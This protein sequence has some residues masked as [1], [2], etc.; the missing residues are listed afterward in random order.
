MSKRKKLFVSI[1]LLAGLLLMV[2]F[3]C[4]KQVTSA[5]QRKLFSNASEVP[6]Q[7]VGLLLGTGKLLENGLANPYYSYRIKAALDLLKA[8]KVDYLIISGD[9]SRKDYNE[10][11]TMRADLMAAGIDSSLIFL[12]FAGFR[13]FDSMVR[14]REI[15]SQDTVTVISQ[16]FHNERALFI[17]KREGIT[18]IGFNAQDVSASAGWKTQLREKLARVKVFMDY[19][20]HKQPKFLGPKVY[21]P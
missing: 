21:I 9:N 3:Y 14:V 19:W 11:E 15:F 6:H 2:I 8:G 17:A 13:T 1:I 20:F 7:H 18:A 12:D 16:Q 4:D 5:A 10:P